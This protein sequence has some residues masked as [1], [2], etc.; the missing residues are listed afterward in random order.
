MVLQWAGKKSILCG[1]S[2]Q[3]DYNEF[4][5]WDSG[6]AAAM[7]AFV[8]AVIYYVFNDHE[9][10]GTLILTAMAAGVG[11][12]VALVAHFTSSR[13]TSRIMQLIGTALCVVFWIYAMH[14]WATTSRFPTGDAA[15]SAE[16]TTTET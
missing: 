11:I 7:L 9:L 5:S 3:E 6:G 10:K 4:N 2:E 12:V 14:K 15:E 13:V 16:T 1:V 8:P